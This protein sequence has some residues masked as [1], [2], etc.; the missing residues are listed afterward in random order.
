MADKDT[1]RSQLKSIR[2]GLTTESRAAKSAAACRSALPELSQSRSVAVYSAIRSELCPRA[3]VRALRAQGITV[4]F[5]RVSPSQRVLEFFAIDSE[6]Q[7]APGALGIL[8]PRPHLEPIPLSDIDALL[9][10]ALG[11]D[12]HGHRLGWG[13]GHYDH[14]LA[15][16]PRALRVGI[17]FQEQ[18]VASLPTESTDAPMDIVITDSERYQGAVRTQRAPAREQK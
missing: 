14:T 9:V 11:F 4:A 6:S 8:E 10:P 17:C 16:C 1:L 15:L 5:P 12:I 3:L 7:L 2:D 13:Q 18:I